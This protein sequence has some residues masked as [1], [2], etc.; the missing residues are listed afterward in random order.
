MGLGA[1]RR[2]APSSLKVHYCQ[3][4]YRAS[5]RRQTLCWT[6][7]Q[8]GGWGGK[9]GSDLLP[10]PKCFHLARFTDG[11]DICSMLIKKTLIVLITLL[12]LIKAQRRV[13]FMAV[14]WMGR[15]STGREIACSGPR[16]SQI[17]T[18]P[19]AF[20]GS[21]GPA[22]YTRSLFSSHFNSASPSEGT[23]S[24]RLAG[25]P[26]AVWDSFRLGLWQI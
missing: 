2:W 24:G 4:S 12:L 22:L 18:Q 6:L 8:L 26:S 17:H 23:C 3:S 9:G 1:E 10:V 25:C 14:L 11:Q 5:V 21:Q 15:P 13:L 7:W 20:S 16:L 19:T